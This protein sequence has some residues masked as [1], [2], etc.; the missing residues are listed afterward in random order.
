MKFTAAFLAM[1]VCTA[2]ASP[3]GNA[4]AL[5]TMVY[6]YSVNANGF[7]KVPG[8]AGVQLLYDNGVGSTS[9]AR[10]GQI[11]VTAVQATSEGGLV[12][13]VA[14]TVDRAAKPLQTIR[15]AIYGA[16]TDVI[17][18]Q[19]V[20]ATIEEQMLL[21]FL[22]RQFLDAS[23]LD[24]KGHWTAVPRVKSGAL[25]LQN[26]FT[27]SNVDG[28][29]ATIQVDRQ[30]RNGG[31][32]SSTSGTVVYDAGMDVPG[33]IKLKTRVTVSGG[34]ADVNLDCELLSD[35]MAKK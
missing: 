11:T 19:N 17:C 5:R 33:S 6:H 3:S 18:D 24:A 25:Y 30:E 32:R 14:E 8:T 22:G 27:V 31:Y 7:G 2:L 15:C 35:S 23:R 20:G 28:K 26:D 13:D 4:D 10:S 9:G 1:S 12:V 34:D 29:K 21:T 16:S